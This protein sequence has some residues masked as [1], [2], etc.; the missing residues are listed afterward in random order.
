MS[1]AT[2]FLFI[3]AGV[4]TAAYILPAADFSD[5]K[6][7]KQLADVVA[8]TTSAKQAPGPAVER[9]A[10]R[11]AQPAPVITPPKPQPAMRE[12]PQGGG[13]SAA[14]RMAAGDI[15]QEPQSKPIEPALPVQAPARKGV[16]GAKAEDAQ[17]M[18]LTR[19]IQRELKRVGCY[20]GDLDGDWGEGTRQAMKTFI[21]RVNATLPTDAPDH[22]LKTLVQGHPGNACGKSCPAGQGLGSDGRCI[23]T[24]ILA[25]PG[26]RAVPTTGRTDRWGGS[27][28]ARAGR[29]ELG[30]ACDRGPGSGRAP[31]RRRRRR[32]TA[33]RR[34]E[35]RGPARGGT[36]RSHGD[37]R[38]C[39][40]TTA[41]AASPDQSAARAATAAPGDRP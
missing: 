29:F 27:R 24:A 5:R 18:A 34:Q 38:T 8:I 39:R 32:A 31:Q 30:D 9:P 7:E 17:R 20:V 33:A 21:D 13:N 14:V 10:P 40:R 35:D 26:K 1:K 22:I 3:L 2:G 16:D 28:T 36:D 4:G 23:P 25:Q 19:D 15:R 11:Q 12:T 37:R 41:C 6:A